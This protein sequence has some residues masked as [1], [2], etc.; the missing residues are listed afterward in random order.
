MKFPQWFMKALHWLEMISALAGILLLALGAVSI[1]IDRP[2]YA[3]E[4]TSFFHAA[5]SFFLLAIM[6]FLIIHLREPVK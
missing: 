6:L 2:V 1:I 3:T 4:I 5:S